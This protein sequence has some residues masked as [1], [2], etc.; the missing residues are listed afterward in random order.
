MT[1]LIK[2]SVIVQP[3]GA[4]KS[5]LLIEDA[6]IAH[7]APSIDAAADNIIDA[8]GLTLLPA[9][10]DMHCHLRDPGQPHK[11]DIASGALSALRGGYAHICCMPNTAPPIDNAAL[12]HYVV[13]KGRET[14]IGVHPIG[15]ITKG[16]EGKELAPMGLM[17]NA[18]AIAFSD[19]G[20]PVDSGAVMALALEYADTFGALII[21]HCEDRSI[22]ADGVANEGVNATIA[23]LRPIPHAA[24]EVMIARDIILAQSKHARLH[25]AHVSTRGSVELVRAA[26]RHGARITCETCPHYFAATDAQILNYNTNAKINPPLRSADDVAAIIEG[27]VD[28]TIDAIATDHAPHSYD[29]KRQEFDLAPFG[30]VGFE[31]AFAV[32]YTYLVK[33]KHIS[34]VHLMQLMSKNPACILGLTCGAI[35]QGASADITMVDLGEQ[36][37]VDAQKFA[38]RGKNSV[39]DGWKLYGSVRS[40]FIGGVQLCK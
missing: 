19:D 28:G 39:F 2:N 40:T 21:S 24:E 6:T 32:S 31:T 25:I 30:S 35:E 9:F 13:S 36:W 29:E 37:V 23:G 26:K 22:S 17:Q 5:D 38:S 4:Q 10:V 11:E 15:A 33:P 7:I 1:T 14:N 16:L 34:I 27:I 12:V 3:H 18:G 20:R 8:H